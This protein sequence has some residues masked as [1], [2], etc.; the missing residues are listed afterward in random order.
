VFSAGHINIGQ[1]LTGKRVA[2]YAFAG[3]GVGKEKPGDDT[4]ADGNEH[5][6]FVHGEK[7]L[8]GALRHS[9]GVGN[10]AKINAS[11]QTGQSQPAQNCD[12]FD[13]HVI[14]SITKKPYHRF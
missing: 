3:F 10:A 6:F 8:N 12:S 1:R 7:G 9:F 14:F 13:I 11:G 4:S 5:M 2:V